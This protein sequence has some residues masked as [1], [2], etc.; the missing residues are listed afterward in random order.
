M[1]E[2]RD[3]FHK[4]SLGNMGPLF[5]YCHLFSLL[6]LR[7]GTLS[8]LLIL[9]SR[10]LISMPGTKYM[11]TEWK[12]SIF[13]LESHNTHSWIKV[14]TSSA[15]MRPLNSAFFRFLLLNAYCSNHAFKFHRIPF[16]KLIS[17]SSLLF[18]TTSTQWTCFSSLNKTY[19]S[20]S[21]WTPSSVEFSSIG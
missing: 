14:L 21:M 9:L 16:G 12:I 13:L 2:G 1:Q 20:P 11:F 4:M 5:I 15:E 18:A 6:S 10:V 17:S 19:L 8:P 3:A 7:E